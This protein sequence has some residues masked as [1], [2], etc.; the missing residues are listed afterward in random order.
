M[1]ENNEDIPRPAPPSDPSIAGMTY[2]EWVDY[3]YPLEPLEPG[4][5][6]GPYDSVTINGPWATARPVP[7]PGSSPA[8]PS[9]PHDH[10]RHPQSL[11]SGIANRDRIG[12]QVVLG[13]SLQIRAEA[14]GPIPFGGWLPAVTQSPAQS[15]A[16][17]GYNLVATPNTDRAALMTRLT[18][19]VMTMTPPHGIPYRAQLKRFQ[20]M[21]PRR[22]I[23]LRDGHNDF[24]PN[25]A[26]NW[27]A[28]AGYVVG[29]VAAEPCIRCQS[30]RGRFTECVIVHSSISAGNRPMAGACSG[31]FHGGAA[32][33]CSFH[34]S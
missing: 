32:V 33:N 15:A 16:P 23:S 27:E 28:A 8:S 20:A 29:D 14:R 24:L 18:N 22:Q 3:K 30:E 9:E 31:C 10:L 13:N 25:R 2:Q 12:D 1:S 26:D 7:I 11:L 4:Y 21:Q 19:Q 5:T 17:I 6:I 34:P